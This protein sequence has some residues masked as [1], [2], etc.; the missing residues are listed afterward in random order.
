MNKTIYTPA[1]REL[2]RQVYQQHN[3]HETCRIIN[4]S[5][6]LNL[7]VHGLRAV[8]CKYGLHKH[9]TR[10]TKKPEKYTEDQAAFL[11]ET[12]AK[13][14]AEETC[15]RFNAK[16][17]ANTNS[18]ALRTWMNKHGIFSRDDGKFHAEQK[19]WNTGTKG[20]TGANKRSY[21]PGM[22]PAKTR[23]VGY[24]RKTT[25]G[26]IEVK[27]SGDWNPIKKRY[28]KWRRKNHI[29]WEQ[30]HGPI[31]AGMVVSFRNGNRADCRVE[32]L[33]LVS[34][35]VMTALRHENFWRQPEEIKPALMTMTQLRMKVAE[36]EAS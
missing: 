29:V 14:D 12:Y 16:F 15:S 24:E 5:L 4:T 17:G 31:P 3:C 1:I 10:R 35:S 25:D 32:N 30:H 34:R 28:G 2:I 9:P 21:K 27:V 23:P 20:L 8:V 26:Y 19:P 36:K 6:G 22:L 13:H 33:V 7:T 18:I 11:R